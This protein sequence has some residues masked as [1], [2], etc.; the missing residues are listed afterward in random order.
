ML[1]YFDLLTDKVGS[2][3][4][5]DDEKYSFINKAQVEYLRRLLPSNE[6]GVVNLENDHV[7]F[8]NAFT[9][10]FETGVLNP[11][12]TGEITRTSVQ[13]AL[14]VVSGSTE[15]FVFPLNVSYNGLPCR[16]TRH[17]DWYEMESNSFKRGSSTE[18]RY[19]QEALKFVVAPPLSTAN[20]QF[21][22][23]K[24]PREV[25]AGVDSEYPGVTH[26]TIVELAVELASVAM[27]DAELN[28]SNQS[29][30]NQ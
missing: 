8:S 13:S 25:G 17:N 10:V 12:S 29:Q 24:Q 18:P 6:G 1:E 20:V 30:L 11:S 7:V 9:L 14:N 16:Y 26:K 23:L 19:R 4:F 28:Q 2:P 22:L 27:R 5:T 3:Y 21:T 15:P